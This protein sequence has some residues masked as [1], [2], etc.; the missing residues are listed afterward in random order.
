MTTA[1]TLTVL[2]TVAPALFATGSVTPSPADAPWMICQRA[3]DET[4]PTPLEPQL[5]AAAPDTL[6]LAA[7]PPTSTAICLNP[8]DP[9][10]AVQSGGSAA[11]PPWQPPAPIL[12]SSAATIMLSMAAL[13][14]LI[15]VVA[16][17]AREGYAPEI[18]E[19]PRT[20]IFTPL[21]GNRR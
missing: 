20:G 12:R 9:G 6:P 4:S 18:D 5:E 10:C 14:D 3:A 21:T 13:G 15:W 1:I 2:A 16:D 11:T 7:D 8:I 19:P 17:R